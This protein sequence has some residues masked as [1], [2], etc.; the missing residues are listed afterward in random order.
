MISKRWHR[1][2]KENDAYLL[3]RWKSEKLTR[4]DWFLLLLYNRIFQYSWFRLRN[5][6][7]LNLFWLDYNFFLNWLW[8]GNN[9]FLNWFWLGNNLYF[10]NFFNYD[11][12]LLWLYWLL[13]DL[14]GNFLWRFRIIDRLLLRLLHTGWP[15]AWGG[16]LLVAFLWLLGH[17]F[18]LDDWRCFD[19]NNWF[20]FCCRWYFFC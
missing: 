3:I 14:F 9:F 17:W 1:H 20:S 10:L 2:R 13:D 16:G 5:D 12:L 18:L 11:G 4:L 19:F 8:F 7:F 6:L 15:L